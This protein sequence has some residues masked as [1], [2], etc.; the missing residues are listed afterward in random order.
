MKYKQIDTTSSLRRERNSNNPPTYNNK[1]FAIPCI[2][3]M[4]SLVKR[5]IWP[6]MAVRWC[7]HLRPFL[8]YIEQTYRITVIAELDRSH[9]EAY[10]AAVVAHREAG[11]KTLTNSAYADDLLSAV[12]MFCRYLYTTE[13][14][15]L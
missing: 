13:D 11:E 3:Y 12:R 10:A 1:G 8:E 7:I 14:Y 9:V 2:R 5:G 6:E 4:E 15:G